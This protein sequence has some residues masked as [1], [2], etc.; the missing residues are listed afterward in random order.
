MGLFSL[1]TADTLDG[2]L[3]IVCPGGVTACAGGRAVSIPQR[4][5]S[6]VVIE[7]RRAELDDVG[8]PAE[9][10]RM[11]RAALGRCDPL[12]M[13]VIA[14]SRRDVGGNLLVTIQA[15]LRLPI[16]IATIMA[17]RTALLV[18]LVR[19]AELA[20]HQQSFRIHSLTPRGESQAQKQTEHP[21]YAP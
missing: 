1:M 13:S 3:S 16:A 19:C 10:F 12:D 7:L 6:R 17:V 8:V 11:T 9:V 18:L 15:Q 20:W 21:E 2:S 4:E 14:V 5:I